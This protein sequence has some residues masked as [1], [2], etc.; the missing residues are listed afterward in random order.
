MKLKFNASTVKSVAKT[1]WKF[2]QKHAPAIA[3]GAAIA[4]MVGAVVSAIKDAP[5]CKQALEEAEIV[6]NEKALQERMDTGD[7]STPIVKLT[8]AEKAAIYI[9]HYWK[10]ILLSLLSATCMIGSVTLSN[11]KI[12]A[13]AVIAAAAEANSDNIEKAVKDVVGEKKFDQIR[14]KVIDD[15][16]DKADLTDKDIINTGNGDTL[17][18]EP[19]LGVYFKS[20]IS[21]ADT[22]VNSFKSQYLSVTEATMD[23]LLSMCGIP[24]DRIPKLA[25]DLGYFYDVED[26]IEYPPTF[27]PQSKL[28][29]LNGIKT[30]VY[31][32]DLGRPRTREELVNEQIA[33]KSF[34]QW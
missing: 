8:W 15:Q 4:T 22:A 13:L 20:S 2:M 25:K 3:A 1:S 29:T 6:K 14:E 5:K 30:T 7:D 28:V 21:A 18:L 11:N 23:E 16:V 26:Q 31:V 24:E 19:W 33:K 27:K 17:V 9:K 34:R 12:K 10:V 32:I